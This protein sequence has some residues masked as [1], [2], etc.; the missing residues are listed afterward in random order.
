VHLAASSKDGTG[1]ALIAFKELEVTHAWQSTA[2]PHCYHAQQFSLLMLY[3]VASDM[4]E[5]LVAHAGNTKEAK[6]LLLLASCCHA[7][8]LCGHKVLVCFELKI[9]HVSLSMLDC[10]HI[11]WIHVAVIWLCCQEGFP[12]S[13]PGNTGQFSRLN[14]P[15]LRLGLLLISCLCSGTRWSAV[16]P[17]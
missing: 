11:I 6:H 10:C 16:L 2:S 8:L 7:L 9:S 5:F 17:V 14:F 3:F 15:C 4:P 13:L 1:T 12:L